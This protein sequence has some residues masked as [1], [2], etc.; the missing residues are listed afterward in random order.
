MADRTVN[1]DREALATL[2]RD[3]KARE[4]ELNN[5]IAEQQ[6]HIEELEKKGSSPAR[7]KTTTS[8]RTLNQQTQGIA[9]EYTALLNDQK[10]IDEVE[11]NKILLEELE[12]LKAEVEDYRKAY[13]NVQKQY[14]ALSKV[15]PGADAVEEARV[16]NENLQELNGWYGELLEGYQ[17]RTAE[18]KELSDYYG[19]LL[20]GY[21]K[22][23]D[24][25]NSL[26]TQ[27]VTLRKRSKDLLST[28]KTYKAEALRL[29]ENIRQIKIREGVNSRD[30][31][32]IDAL[33]LAFNENVPQNERIQHSDDDYTRRKKLADMIKASQSRKARGTSKSYEET[34]KRAYENVAYLL[35]PN[36]SDNDAV[37]E[38]AGLYKLYG[39]TY[40]ED[41][42]TDLLKE[43]A[44][45][46][47]EARVADLTRGK[48]QK[49]FVKK[50]IGFGLAVV[51]G[52]TIL[53]VALGLA[54]K[55]AVDNRRLGDE[56][57]ESQNQTLIANQESEFSKY[58][59]EDANN[60]GKHY[61]E[62][63]AVVDTA[64]QVFDNNGITPSSLSAVS[65]RGAG[66][67]VYTWDA[68]QTAKSDVE[69]FYKLDDQG[70]LDPSCDY[71]KAVESYRS[72][73]QGG[74]ANFTQDLAD[75]QAGYLSES[76]PLVSVME[77]TNIA[78][79]KNAYV[80]AATPALLSELGFTT[81]QDGT[82]EVDVN[83]DAV[84][85]YNDVLRDNSLGGMAVSVDA[86]KYTKATGG[87]ELLVRCVDRRDR[88]FTSV[89][90]YTIAPN[91]SY[92]SAKTL[93]SPLAEQKV[94]ATRTSYNRSLEV[95][96]DSATVNF[97][98]QEVSGALEV[99]CSI[100][101]KYN[102]KSDTTTVKASALVL[103]DGQYKEFSVEKTFDGVKKASEVENTMKASL[104]KSINRATGAQLEMVSPSSELEKQ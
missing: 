72:N 71:A 73:I 96:A 18:C 44:K 70:K 94:D 5:Q 68:V 41:S 39:L 52:L 69:A 55:Q 45:T 97:D 86:A 38:I 43:V 103:V 26:E 50:L 76:N 47:T 95:N 100:T 75:Y 36:A 13:E 32:L 60:V 16:A 67:D 48:G 14:E 84:I 74:L 92:V 62:L 23:K 99:A 29:A 61:G 90:K 21:D 40:R 102:E 25:E 81:S 1:N 20:E 89:I 28:A 34:M 9:D 82:I 35:A 17:Q 46:R 51:T 33:E 87:V 77:Y 24:K 2:V 98:G 56:L 93:L 7:R 31:H 64:T 79:E 88:E 101:T 53:G 12:G 54:P 6:K 91:Q 78:A 104:V 15:V 57:G 11:G 10:Y 66:E 58:L 63:N 42:A 37:A 83:N 4:Q 3:L 65:V 85:E 49:G 30:G 22:L 80:Q 59:G 19:N 8:R 27:I